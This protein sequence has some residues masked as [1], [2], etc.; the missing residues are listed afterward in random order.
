MTP[1]QIIDRVVSFEKDLAAFYEDLELKG[2]L[3]PLEKVC[4]FMAQ[5]SAIHAEMIA[6]YRS[7]AK[8]PQLEINP[9][10]I[11]HDRLKTSLRDALAATDDID[12][13][14]RQLSQAEEI[15]GHAY[16]KIADHYAQVADAYRMIAGKFDA[17][18]ADERS[19]RDHII[20]ENE[21]LKTTGAAL[22]PDKD[23]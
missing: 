3:K 6:N 16:A 13:A 22:P 4:R 5:H 15:V 10:G 21:R 8:I 12:Q 2:S 23:D 17:L 9:L 14:A 7:N 11:L 20:K 18:A 1:Q 19:H